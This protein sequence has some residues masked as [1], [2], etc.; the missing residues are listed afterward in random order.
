M[1]LHKTEI[2]VGDLLPVA[3]DACGICGSTYGPFTVAESG[4][5]GGPMLICESPTR[6]IDRAESAPPAETRTRRD[7]A[8]ESETSDRSDGAE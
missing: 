4:P 2:E 6:C 5:D 1:E 7:S 8:A 3:P